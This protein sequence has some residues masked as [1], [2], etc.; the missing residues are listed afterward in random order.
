MIRL[1][2]LLCT[3]ALVLTLGAG[4][5]TAQAQSYPPAPPP[6]APPAPP[7]GVAPGG[8]PPVPVAPVPQAIPVA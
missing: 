1:P 8:P 6:G 3:A 5:A 7:P 4:I 2:H